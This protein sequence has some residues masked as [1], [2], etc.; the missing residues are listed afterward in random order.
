VILVLFLLLSLAWSLPVQAETGVLLRDDCTTI[1]SPVAGSTFCFDR[2]NNVLKKYTGSAWVASNEPGIF[3]TKE[4]GLIGNG[5]TD[6][7]PAL[8][9]LAAAMTTGGTIMFDGPATYR[10][11]TCGPAGGFWPGVRFVNAGEATLSKECNGDLFS[12]NAAKN[13]LIDLVVDANGDTYTGAVVRCK[14]NSSQFELAGGRY[15]SGADTILLFEDNGC[16]QSLFHD[17]YYDIHVSLVATGAAVKRTVSVVDTTASP[18]H[19]HHILGGA[20][21][22][23]ADVNGFHGAYFDH[24]YSAGINIGANSLGNTLNNC[25]FAIPGAMTMTVSGTSTIVT[26]NEINSG[27][28][29]IAAG[30][31]Y[32]LFV[33]NAMDPAGTFT[34]S[35]I[36]T[37]LATQ[38]LV[39]NPTLATGRQVTGIAT[40]DLPAAAASMG[41]RIIIEDAGAGDR[42]LILYFGGQRFRIDGGAGF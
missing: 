17:F 41:S 34:D 35:S 19:F 26:A 6:D 15:E 16:S 38:P 33:N 7:G 30:F 18:R 14:A 9:A 12:I 13:A 5:S 21:S 27:A 11:A 37:G 28:L 40:A 10:L 25:R 23:F 29:T 4:N 20:S 3:H 31:V 8:W 22:W 39:E 2:T 36:R 42:N 1:S 32:G 24:V